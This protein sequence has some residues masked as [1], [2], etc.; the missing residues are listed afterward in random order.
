MNS[1]GFRCY[2]ALVILLAALTLLLFAHP[3]KADQAYKTV[4]EDGQVTCFSHHYSG[5]SY[6][7]AWGPVYHSQAFRDPVDHSLAPWS[8][9]RSGMVAPFNDPTHGWVLRKTAEN[10]ANGAL[11]EF[12]NPVS[13]FRL[14]LYARKVN[15]SGGNAV[16]YSL[17][18]A[19]G[20][21]Y[22]FFFDSGTDDLTIETRTAWLSNELGTSDPLDGGMEIGAW[23]TMR[24]TF[25][26]GEL[27]AQV[28]EGRVNPDDVGHDPVLSVEAQDDTYSEFTHMGINGGHD[29]DT[30]EI[31]VKDMGNIM[32][33]VRV[34]HDDG[35]VQDLGRTADTKMTVQTTRSTNQVFHARAVDTV[36]G[37]ASGWGGLDNPKTTHDGKA[38][39]IIVKPKPPESTFGDGE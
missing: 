37:E 5:D 16:R 15:E 24:L 39:V 19:A 3:V 38:W 33:D 35:T 30:D 13:S 29:F 6:T 7:I 18:N 25:H 36:S 11:V 14:T 34:V 23:Y 10:D 8:M 22:G 31:L 26:A 27:A 9:F 20:D 1:D 28:Y 4:C 32:Y 21:G 2:L 17:V 12:D